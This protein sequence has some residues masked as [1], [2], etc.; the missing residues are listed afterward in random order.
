MTLPVKTNSGI[1][2]T[3]LIEKALM[4]VG[5]QT[6]EEV[7]SFVETVPVN[8]GVSISIATK[9]QVMVIEKDPSTRYTRKSKKN[10]WATNHFVSNDLL[11]NNALL[12]KK[13]PFHASF[14]RYG[15]I[16]SGIDQLEA[17][18]DDM[19]NLLRD[20]PLNQNFRD[21][22]F[23]CV[24]AWVTVIELGVKSKTIFSPNNL[25]FEAELV[26]DYM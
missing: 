15:Y 19:L 23:N 16:E 18:A 14:P 4:M 26:L 10:I 1:S 24:T 2:V 6:I 7:I 3:H 11:K 22:Q 13:I 5:N 25:D 8:R 20:A 17:N 21:P 9:T 12:F